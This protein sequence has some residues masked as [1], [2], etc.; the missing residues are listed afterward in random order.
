MLILF[1]VI[2]H[3]KQIENDGIGQDGLGGDIVHGDHKTTFRDGFLNTCLLPSHYWQNIVLDKI[4]LP[5][6]YFVRS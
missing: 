2:H 6:L 1:T 5:Y 4:V 3:A